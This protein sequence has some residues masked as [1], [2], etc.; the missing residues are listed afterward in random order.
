[1]QRPPLA[2]PL[3]LLL[4]PLAPKRRVLSGGSQPLP[5]LLLAYDDDDEE[6]ELERD[7]HC[8]SRNLVSVDVENRRR[9][10]KNWSMFVSDVF[11]EMP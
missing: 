7:G 11:H 9:D 3:P 6:N 10:A 8:V 5:H 1:M 2:C 4:S